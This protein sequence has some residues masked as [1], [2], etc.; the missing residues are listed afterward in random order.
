MVLM[1][2]LM[3]GFVSGIMPFSLICGVALLPVMLKRL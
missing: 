1:I 3:A 2:L